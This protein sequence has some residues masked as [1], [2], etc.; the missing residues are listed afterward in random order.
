MPPS[1]HATMLLSGRAYEWKTTSP[2]ENEIA[3]QIAQLWLCGGKPREGFEEDQ[4]LLY[5]IYANEIPTRLVVR[6]Q[7]IVVDELMK[8]RGAKDVIIAE[9]IKERDALKER[10]LELEFAPGGLGAIEA[11]KHFEQRRG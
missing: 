7:S 11:Q 8:Q 9:L 4:N 10:N 5:L 3:E 1:L 2:Q 6:A